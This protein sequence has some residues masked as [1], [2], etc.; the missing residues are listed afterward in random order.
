MS[1]CAAEVTY[2]PPRAH[3][4]ALRPCVRFDAELRGAWLADANPER[5]HGQSAALAV[6]ELA[7]CASSGRA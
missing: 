2:E 1:G 3:E 7:P 6:P 4:L 5:Q